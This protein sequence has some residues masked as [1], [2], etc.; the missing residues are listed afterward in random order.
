MRPASKRL[1]SILISLGFLI[2]AIVVFSSLV[3]PEY[4]EIQ[5]LRG[6]KKSLDLAAKEAEGLVNTAT[7]LINEYQSATNLRDNL[8]LILP[9][10]EAVPGIVNQV[11]GIAR[12][13][14][15]IVEAINIEPLPLTYSKTDSVI[16]PAGSFKVT[17]RVRGNYEALRSYV[18]SL[19]TNARI[20]DVDSFVISGGGTSGPLITNLVIRTYYQR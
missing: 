6:E 19:E 5:Q 9:R 11:Q 7:R 18:Q 17:L 15:V 1:F 13:T 16:E 2:G 14:G 3:R 8:S 4:R 10:E 20:I 12:T